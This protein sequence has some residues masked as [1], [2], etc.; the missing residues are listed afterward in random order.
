MIKTVLHPS[1]GEVFFHR[2]KGHVPKKNQNKLE[3]LLIG[4]EFPW[5][6]KAETV[7]QKP[8]SLKKFL[9]YCFNYLNTLNYLFNNI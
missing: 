8:K 2:V 1:A 5:R 7:M 6:Y 3:E 9:F 4:A